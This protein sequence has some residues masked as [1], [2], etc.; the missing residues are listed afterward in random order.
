[1][2]FVQMSN[3]FLQSDRQE[4]APIIVMCWMISALIF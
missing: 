2:K 4:K 1:M 3:G